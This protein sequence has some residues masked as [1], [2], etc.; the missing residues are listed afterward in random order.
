M[1]VRVFPC[2]TRISI[3]NNKKFLNMYINPHFL[4]N[5]HHG[6]RINEQN[7]EKS[8]LGDRKN[9]ILAE[10]ILI[11]LDDFDEPNKNTRQY[12]GNPQEWKKIENI[13]DSCIKKRT[14]YPERYRRAEEEEDMMGDVQ[15]VGDEEEE[16]MMGDVQGVGDEEE[17]DMM[18]DVQG[19]EDEEEEDI[20]G[21][22]QAVGD[23][24]EEDM[25]DV[26]GVGYRKHGYSYIYDDEDEYD[27]EEEEYR[28]RQLQHRKMIQRQIKRQQQN[29]WKED[30]S[31][32]DE[33]FR[34]EFKRIYN[35]YS[36]RSLENRN[37]NRQL[38]KTVAK[39]AIPS[40]PAI[41]LVAATGGAATPV[42]IGAVIN[43]GYQIKKAMKFFKRDRNV[44]YY[45]RN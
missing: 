10:G 17:E 43:N 4:Q 5:I 24:E 14:G 36:Y 26:R 27:E 1:Y 31:I 22:V 45:L 23:E 34:Q 7:M 9:R 44:F 8:V 33:H 42:A 18:G 40:I 39:M 28:H 21:D 15:G 11:Q 30:E 35:T 12:N 37:L 38:L 3:E 13:I 32:S 19:V 41:A 16:D 20:M 6:C 25:G 2:N 29:A